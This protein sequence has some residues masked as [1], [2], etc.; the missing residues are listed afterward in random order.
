MKRSC[1]SCG[2]KFY[3]LRKPQIV[4]PKC[5]TAFDPQIVARPQRQRPAAVPVPAPAEEVE[6]EDTDVELEEEVLDE[7]G[8]EE[9]EVIEDASELGGDKDD[10]F[11]VIEKPEGEDER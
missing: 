3:D 8:E 1:Q 4:C 6:L 5:G 9:D 11:E 10:M 7:E 2:A